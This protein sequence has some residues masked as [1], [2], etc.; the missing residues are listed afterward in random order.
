MPDVTKMTRNEL[1]DYEYS[2]GYSMRKPSKSEQEWFK[3]HK[4]IPGYAAEDGAIVLNPHVSLSPEQRRGV[5]MN[6]ASRLYMRENKVIPDF[7]ITP[8]Q[9]ES[10]KGSPYEKNAEA[11]KQTLVGRIISNDKSAG[12]VTQM[13]RDYSKGIYEQLRGRT[14]Q[15]RQH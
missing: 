7:D 12:K 9:I 4:E 1:D 5:I 6:E 11:M 14:W 10:F 2:F 3:E 15:G 13:Q 8:E